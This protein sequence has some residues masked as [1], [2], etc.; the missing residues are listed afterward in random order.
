[1]PVMRKTAS[2]LL[3]LLFAVAAFAYTDRSFSMTVQV[4]GSGNAHVIEK[5]VFTLDTQEETN[6]FEYYLLQGK[7]T[8][9]DWQR[10]S[11]NI[12]YHYSGALSNLRII[13]AREFELGYTA[14]S[15]S[16][17]YDVSA[18]FLPEVVNNRVT[19]YSLDKKKLSF[20]VP[21]ELSL[22]SGHELHME[23][24][25]DAFNLKLIP[26]GG[27]SDEGHNALS[28]KG[29]LI[30]IWDVSFEREASLS[31]EV[32]EFFIDSYQ[33]LSESYLWLIALVFLAVIAVKLIKLRE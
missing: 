20:G 13:A 5:T 6:T 23:L 32:K 4:S 1:M 29:P 19:R 31:Q 14:A 26:V 27:V 33:G 12:R 11:K 8:L 18:L 21:G 15:V 3:L 2:L 24:P 9:I 22:S 25:A 30:G 16:I 10:F 7:S 28:W 17:E